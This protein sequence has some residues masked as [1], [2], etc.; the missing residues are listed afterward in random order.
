MNSSAAAQLINEHGA[1]ECEVFK[2]EGVLRKAGALE[3]G[4]PVSQAV[5]AAFMYRLV[6]ASEGETRQ[7]YPEGFAPFIES[8]AG[9]S[10]PY[11]HAVPVEILDVWSDLANEV[12][13]PA[14]AAR[15]HDLLW[16]AHYGAE[17]VI[18]ATA[19]IDSY[20]GA[21][22]VEGCRE[23]FTT[24]FFE[25]A[26]ELARSIGDR[27]R[28]ESVIETMSAAV[29]KELLTVDAPSTA[30]GFLGKL[31]ILAGLDRSERPTDLDELLEIAER[32]LTQEPLFL[33]MDV[34]EIRE[35]A[36]RGNS[37][38]INAIRRAEVELL[39]AEAR[40]EEGLLRT[41]WLYEAL[42]LASRIQGADELANEIRR[43]IQAH[44]A[45]AG[46][47]EISSEVTVP[48]EEI[49]KLIEWV[50]GDDD[51]EGSLR[52]FGAW[53]PPSGTVGDALRH[54]ENLKRDHPMQFLVS[55]MVVHPEGYPI[56]ELASDE[57]KSAHARAQYEVMG[58][59]IHAL[60]AIEA[61]DSMFERHS[62]SLA[63]LTDALSGG[64]I[65]SAQAEVFARAF[66]HYYEGRWDECVHVA[67]PRIE[68]IFREML[69]SAGG[70][71]YRE[72]RGQS[73]GGVKTLG[74][75]LGGLEPLID[76]DW[77]RFLWVLLVEPFGLNLRNEYLHGLVEQPTQQHAVLVLKVIAYLRLLRLEST[78]G[79]PEHKGT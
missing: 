55:R 33:R 14:A 78:P 79:T 74:A 71:V 58:I 27:G 70:I 59:G 48:T 1:T 72:E 26:L 67:L 65:R 29:R 7:N 2:I 57:A 28:L 20:V 45:G 77:W 6:T 75:I 36:S 49:T 42:Q 68:T 23:I 39:L 18:H 15:L 61:V 22:S 54:V 24:D 69:R 43:E 32:L 19:A 73:V 52:R 41:N 3:A 37:E 76:P 25:R 13:A 44:D 16:A 66:V 10:P 50:V 40:E 47:H 38:A 5:T 46:L 60:L 30:G 31:R 56:S 35:L 62:P 63:E 12:T 64:P 4:D 51:L 53:G 17:P 9:V 21:T 8:E 11:V 34:L